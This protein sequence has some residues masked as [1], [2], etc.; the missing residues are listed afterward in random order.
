LA[1]PEEISS[2]TAN[3]VTGNALVCYDPARASEGDV[4]GYLR[5]MFEIFVRNRE[6][7]EGLEPEDVPRLLENLQA[8]VRD[9]VKPGLKVNG[10][11]VLESDVLE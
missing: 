9:A 2:A 7:F 5:S 11:M 6:R 1:E 4:I 10:K 3:L 8:V